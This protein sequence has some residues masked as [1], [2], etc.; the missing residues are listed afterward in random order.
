MTD[1][2]MPGSMDG[3]ALAREVGA[4]YPHLPVVL[5]SGYSDTP[6]DPQA[7]R[8]L[9]KPYQRAE[10]ATTLADALAG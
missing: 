4:H 7:Q 6:T 3:I 2:V 1:V 9:A 8:C 10:L 5:A